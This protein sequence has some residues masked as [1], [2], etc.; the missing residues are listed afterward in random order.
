MIPS[1]ADPARSQAVRWTA[2][3]AIN[4]IE[5]LRDGDGLTAEEIETLRTLGDDLI[6]AADWTQW[7]REESFI[8]GLFAHE[9]R[10]KEAVVR[11]ASDFSAEETSEFRR[12]SMVLNELVIEPARA[13]AED[14]DAIEAVCSLLIRRLESRA[15]FTDRSQD[16][17]TSQMFRSA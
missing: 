11:D 4:A 13:S 5:N 9:P 6:G 8:S 3:Q 17:S 1:L 10:L 15:R 14:L 16:S 7:V 12:L 2:I